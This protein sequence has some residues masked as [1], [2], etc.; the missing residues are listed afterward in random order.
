MRFQTLSILVISLFVAAVSQA[1]EASEGQEQFRRFYASAGVGFDYSTGDYGD[2]EKSHLYASS[3]FAK[4]EYEP[5]TVKVLVPYVVV[6]GDLIVGEEVGSGSASSRHGIGDIVTTLAYAHFSEAEYLPTIV[7]P[8]IKIK[9][10]SGSE[11]K[12]LGTGHTD[13]TFGLELA[14][15]FGSV[16]VF[17]SGAYRT[18]GGSYNDIWLASLGTSVK[19]GDRVSAGLAYDFRQASTNGVGDS[20]E[21]APMA[22]FRVSERLRFGPYAVI[23]LSTNSPDWGLG[24]MFTVNF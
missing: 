18:K 5:I 4:L 3:L 19:L 17:G 11:N 21:I 6:D 15:M 12:D 7:E 9:I 10:P 13:V 14:K 22:S 2:P 24:G 1:G 23:G 16:T 8:S 20:H